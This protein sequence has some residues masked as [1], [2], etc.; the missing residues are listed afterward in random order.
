M[1]MESPQADPEQT[2][3]LLF[4][5]SQLD[6]KFS[7]TINE[8]YSSVRQQCQTTAALHI[9][10]NGSL[11][12]SQSNRLVVASQEAI[13]NVQD[14]MRA[15]YQSFKEQKDEKARALSTRALEH[16]FFKLNNALL[17]NE[18]HK[19]IVQDNEL[20]RMH[21][22]THSKCENL[23]NQVA[24]LESERKNLV[25]RAITAENQQTLLQAGIDHKIR[26]YSQIQTSVL[27]LEGQVR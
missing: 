14:C 17:L 22:T 13:T 18:S 26:Q 8:S 3:R 4:L 20:Q 15:L 5:S 27:G 12:P 25:E 2:E 7:I 9:F 19:L 1:E 10:A 24:S 11:S 21:R 6:D 23:K 16:G